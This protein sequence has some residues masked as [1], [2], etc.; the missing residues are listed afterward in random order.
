MYNARVMRDDYIQNVASSITSLLHGENANAEH[1]GQHAAPH[2]QKHEGENT[3]SN[4]PAKL[5]VE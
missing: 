2:Q 4:A 5:R 3:G 1:Q